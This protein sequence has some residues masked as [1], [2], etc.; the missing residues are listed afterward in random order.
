MLL[1]VHQR[2]RRREKPFGCLCLCL[3]RFSSGLGCEWGGKTMGHLGSQRDPRRLAKEHRLL[4]DRV[5]ISN[6]ILS[7]GE[8]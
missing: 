5:V 1:S 2:K 4:K 7:H 8:L 3:N 6:G